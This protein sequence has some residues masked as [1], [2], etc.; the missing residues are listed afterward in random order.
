MIR[1][2]PRSTLFPYT[3]LFRSV[4]D[5]AS[6]AVV[7]TARAGR[8]PEGV[9]FNRDNTKLYAVNENEQAV[10]VLDAKTWAVI[11]AIPVGTEPETAVL[12]P[13]GKWID[14]KSVV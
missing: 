14:R 2:P 13:D 6:L 9:T 12:S 3:T 5:A 4:I 11:K 8:D 1:R 7:K 10:T